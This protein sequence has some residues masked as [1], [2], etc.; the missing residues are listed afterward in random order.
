MSDWIY[1]MT[2][3]PAYIPNASGAYVLLIL[4]LRPT[5]LPSVR[6]SGLLDPGVYAYIGSAYGPGGIRARCR[7]HFSRRKA[8]HWHVDWLTTDCDWIDA[9]AWPDSNECELVKRFLPLWGIS[10][11]I[12]GFGNSDCRQCISHLLRLEKTFNTKQ[13]LPHYCLK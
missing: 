9:I 1:S 10:T 5:R 13:M 12:A 7:R 4:L 11:A 3:L 6:F 2:F 8:R